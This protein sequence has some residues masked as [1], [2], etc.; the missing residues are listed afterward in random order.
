MDPKQSF[1]LS[2]VVFIASAVGLGIAALA[3]KWPQTHLKRI[4]GKVGAV[5]V[6]LSIMVTFRLPYGVQALLAL[7]L[8]ALFWWL[9]P[10]YMHGMEASL[11]E[12]CVV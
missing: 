3:L 4:L 10:R 2:L 9:F 7:P 1:V 11:P 12:P 5:W 6:F 8:A